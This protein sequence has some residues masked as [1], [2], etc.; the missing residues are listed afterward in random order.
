MQVMAEDI[1]SLPK[2]TMALGCCRKNCEF[3]LMVDKGDHTWGRGRCGV[4]TE[5]KLDGELGVQGQ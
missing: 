1:I 4:I 5:R 3:L 2:M